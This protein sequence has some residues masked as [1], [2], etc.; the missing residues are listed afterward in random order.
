MQSPLFC[1]HYRPWGGQKPTPFILDVNA[2]TMDEQSRRQKNENNTRGREIRKNKTVCERT[3]HT[4]INGKQTTR[5]KDFFPK[6]LPQYRR[7]TS[8][9]KLTY[10]DTTKTKAILLN[11]YLRTKRR[12]NHKKLLHKEKCRRT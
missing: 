7:K 3:N 4:Q 12:K 9:A 10:T 2:A 11:E 1:L 5:Q 6:Q 8:G